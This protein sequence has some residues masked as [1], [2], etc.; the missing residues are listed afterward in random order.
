MKITLKDGAAREFEGPM[1]ALEV[2]KRISNSLAKQAVAVR[3]NG[4]VM[5]LTTPIHEDVEME[6]L[7]FA[8]PRLS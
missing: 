1:S 8:D 5:D 3:I 4:K 7:T 2:V 6:V